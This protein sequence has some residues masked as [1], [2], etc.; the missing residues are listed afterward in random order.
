MSQ[1]TIWGSEDIEI[2]QPDYLVC[3]VCI[4]LAQSKITE[5]GA[6]L[7][8]N[9]LSGTHL[10][11]RAY[12]PLTYMWSAYFSNQPHTIES[13]TA[14]N[15]LTRFCNTRIES[16]IKRLNEGTLAWKTF[17]LQLIPEFEISPTLVSSHSTLVHANSSCI[18]RV[19]QLSAQKTSPEALR[20]RMAMLLAK[21]SNT[22]SQD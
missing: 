15:A 7:L 3:A 2:S 6:E 19:Q 11:Y 1:V 17:P 10:G 18:R 21:A 22:S 12:A 13:Y 14:F 4:L 8:L 16:Y 9:R 20:L 5:S